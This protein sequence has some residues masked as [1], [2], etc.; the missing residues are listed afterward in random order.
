MG[1]LPPM[2]RLRSYLLVGLVAGAM[3]WPALRDP[4]QDSFPL[5]DYPMFS[6]GRPDPNL[7]I[8]HALGV[9]EAGAETPL[10][11]MLSS[12]NR[13]VLQS[14]MSLHLGVHSGPER[15]AAYCREIAERVAADSGQDGTVA[16]AL[17]TSTYD[18]VGYFEGSTEPLARD[19]HE[20]C[21]VSRP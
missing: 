5:S 7:T 17:V 20:R 8:T 14:M 19:V 6:A 4:P 11:P 18:S 1:M 15:R 13:E 3:V 10:S 12:A 16:V 21:D 2:E 9:D